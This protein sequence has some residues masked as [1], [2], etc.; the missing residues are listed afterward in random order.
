MILT[1]VTNEKRVAGND[2]ALT[3]PRVHIPIWNTRNIVSVENFAELN[4]FTIF[5]IDID[6][7][8]GFFYFEIV[9]FF[10]LRWL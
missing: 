7:P 8:L 4:N 6:I 2:V 9:G 10:E 3:I 1:F 5:W